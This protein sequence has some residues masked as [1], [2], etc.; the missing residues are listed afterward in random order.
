[1]QLWI[2]QFSDGSFCYIPKAFVA[3]WNF[4]F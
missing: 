4:P 1:M 3:Q 2:P